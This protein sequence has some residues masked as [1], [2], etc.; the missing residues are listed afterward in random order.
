MIFCFIFSL[1]FVICGSS[2][3][4]YPNLTDILIGLWNITL[5]VIDQVNGKEYYQ[6]RVYY[7]LELKKSGKSDDLY[8]FLYTFYGKSKDESDISIKLRKKE[9]SN[10]VYSVFISTSDVSAFR[11][12][13]NLNIS[14][15]FNGIMAGSGKT[16]LN[17]QFSFT[18]SLPNYAEVITYEQ[19]TK[20]PNIYRFVKISFQD[21]KINR[22][23]MAPIIIMALISAF[24][25]ISQRSDHKRKFVNYDENS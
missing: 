12:I 10:N 6:S 2:S 25:S 11:E 15:S 16:Y 14:S 1:F 5:Y 20:Q 22:W 4:E 21:N 23:R 19:N 18:I 8:G 3:P 17:D 24:K 9:F 7:S 13:A